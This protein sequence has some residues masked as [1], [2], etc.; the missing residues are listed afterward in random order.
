MKVGEKLSRKYGRQASDILNEYYKKG[1]GKF[2]RAEEYKR[3][4]E[5]QKP[6]V[7][8]VRIEIPSLNIKTTKRP[9]HGKNIRRLR[10][11]GIGLAAA[12]ALA[13]GGYAL[14]KKKGKKDDNN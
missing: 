11:A 10:G 9:P 12:G 14:S 1:A 5:K 8:G 13:A 3:A 7:P 4:L 2:E 6:W